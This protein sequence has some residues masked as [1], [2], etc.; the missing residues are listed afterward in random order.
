MNEQTLDE[1]LGHFISLGQTE[2]ETSFQRGALCTAMIDRGCSAEWIAEKS[3]CSAS[4]VRELRKTWSAFPT[5][6]ERLPYSELYFYHFRLAAGT[7]DPHY[8]IGQAAEHNWSTRQ[9][10]EAI[11]GQKIIDELA[12]A[13]RVL[14][15]IE[16]IMTEGGKPADYLLDKL[17]VLING[18]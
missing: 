4:L 5:E 18:A 2:T 9:L 12:E 15:K 10:R 6:E 13:D 8:W 11:A 16:K 7:D 3:N 17:S 14:H 1:I